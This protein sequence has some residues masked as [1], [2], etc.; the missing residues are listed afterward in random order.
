M[1]RFALVLL[2]SLVVGSALAS[3][4]SAEPSSGDVNTSDR[5][6]VTVYTSMVNDRE[7][8]NSS[9]TDGRHLPPSGDA[10]PSDAGNST[11]DSRDIINPQPWIK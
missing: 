6:N 4:A 2:S 9:V 5:Y 3:T 10:N 11:V 1:K 7:S 8:V